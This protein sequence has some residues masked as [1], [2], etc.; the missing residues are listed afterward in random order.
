MPILATPLGESELDASEYLERLC[1][2]IRQT[3]PRIDLSFAGGEC[4][5]E[6]RNCRHLGML[7]SEL[8]ENATRLAFPECHGS[9]RIELTHNDAA[10]ICRVKDN[11]RGIADNQRGRGMDIV[12][13]LAGRL[14]A[15]LG[16]SSGPGGTTWIIT[17][18]RRA[19]IGQVTG[20]RNFAAYVSAARAR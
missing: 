6:A 13:D 15:T 8:I 9:I 10:A 20:R 19:R 4:R 11:G 1:Q 14:H 12:Y 7:V 16:R 17:I 5:L 3:R 2:S 18:P